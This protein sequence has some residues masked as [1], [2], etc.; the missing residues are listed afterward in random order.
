VARVCRTV[1]DLARHTD[2]VV[3]VGHSR[4]GQIALVAATR[5]VRSVCVVVTVGTPRQIGVPDHRF[6]RAGARV[7]RLAQRLSL[8]VPGSLECG[9]GACCQRFRFDLAHG[10]SVIC[11][12]L[13][14]PQDRIVPP[15]DLLLRDPPGVEIEGGHL[16]LVLFRRNVDAICSTVE[17]LVIRL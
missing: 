7:A 1:S 3:L 6:A 8:P 11:T 9:H 16:Q 14:S 12:A 5:M 4:G 15:S 10:S 17:A 13:W 2:R